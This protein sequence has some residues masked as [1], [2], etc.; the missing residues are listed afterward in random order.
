MSD[1]LAICQ[2]SLFIVILAYGQANMKQLAELEINCMKMSV[3]Q[4]TKRK[5]WLLRSYSFMHDIFPQ[6]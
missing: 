3:I 2:K 6:S 4:P 1:F 5:F